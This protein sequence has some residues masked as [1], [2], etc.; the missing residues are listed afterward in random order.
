MR[1]AT[2]RIQGH[3]ITKIGP[4]AVLEFDGDEA[5][6]KESLQ[7]EV[8][9]LPE[10]E[11]EALV[12]AKPEADANVTQVADEI[13]D[14]LQCGARQGENVLVWCEVLHEW[15]TALL[16]AVEA[17]PDARTPVPPEVLARLEELVAETTYFDFDHRAST[18]IRA[19][20]PHIRASDPAPDF[21][22][23]TPDKRRRW[24]DARGRLVVEPMASGTGALAVLF[25]QDTFKVITSA[26]EDRESAALLSLCI[27]VHKLQAKP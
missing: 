25:V 3:A 21:S 20:L 16:A 10:E 19:A 13:E 4:L 27:D 7:G 23:M 17:A 6:G 24:L 8:I 26:C 11:Y 14:S 18:A 22:A 1:K 15:H 12:A 5:W 2:I 9:V